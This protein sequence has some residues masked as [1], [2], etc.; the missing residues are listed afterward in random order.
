M[1]LLI[2]PFF[3]V[4]KGGY[5]LLTKLNLCQLEFFKKI[6]LPFREALFS[7]IFENNYI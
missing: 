7:L 1:L 5:E 6:F 3:W 2:E 4:E